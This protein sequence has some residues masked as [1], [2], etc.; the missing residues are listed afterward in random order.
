MKTHKL[1]E[2][3]EE[4]TEF[5]LMYSGRKPSDVNLDILMNIKQDPDDDLGYLA[6]W[7]IDTIV[8]T[9]EKISWGFQEDSQYIVIIICGIPAFTL[10]TARY[11]CLI[12]ILN[13]SC[14]FVGE[15]QTI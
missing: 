13:D 4:F 3:P 7:T 6:S 15:W 10:M 1:P 8:R 5:V 9:P 12:D 14:R 2:T 11:S